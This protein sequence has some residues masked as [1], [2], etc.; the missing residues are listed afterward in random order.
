MKAALSDGLRKV[1]PHLNSGEDPHLNSHC[2]KVLP[3][4]FGEP[5]SSSANIARALWGNVEL[6]MLCAIN[7]A[8]LQYT[9]F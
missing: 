9:H 7:C 1:L 3:S 6:Q 5:C 2:T 4:H 8:S